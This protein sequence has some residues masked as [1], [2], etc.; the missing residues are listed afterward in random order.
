MTSYDEGRLLLPCDQPLQPGSCFEI[1][2]SKRFY[3][4]KGKNRCEPF[5]YGG[6]FGNENNF[7]TEHEC[8]RTCVEAT[9]EFLQVHKKSWFFN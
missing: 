2:D 9:P 3:Y 4:N 5:N 6:C 7:E 1:F 8:K